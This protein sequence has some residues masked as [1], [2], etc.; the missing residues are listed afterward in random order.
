M[1][2]LNFASTFVPSSLDQV[3][4]TSSV[5]AIDL[6]QIVNQTDPLNSS[7]LATFSAIWS[8]S[9]SV[10]SDQLFTNQSQYTFFYRTQTNISVTIGQ[11][12]FY[13]SN[14]QQ[15]IARQTEIIFHCLLFTIV[16]LEVFGLLFLL[17]KLLFIPVFRTI[18][19]HFRH[20]QLQSQD[21]SLS[22]IHRNSINGHD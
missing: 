22:V 11:D 4:A 19:N 1:L 18:L 3:L 20:K 14:L 7:G 12:I 16:V 13:I 8:Y 6:T 17:M 5:F 9:L 15:P 21:T 10:A 2:D